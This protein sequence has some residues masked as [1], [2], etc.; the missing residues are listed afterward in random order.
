MTTRVLHRNAREMPPVAVGGKGAY[1]I[2]DHGCRYLDGS[3]VVCSLGY[4]HPAVIAAIRDQ[5]DALA[6]A[7]SGFFTTEALEG[8][9]A[10]LVARAPRSL[11]HAYAVSGGS[12]AVEAALKLA[13]QYFVERGQPGRRHVITRWRSV[14]T[15]LLGALA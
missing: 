9:A 12:E 10:D 6:Y 11:D 13:K 7:H 5:L 2:D 8:L 3:A 15:Q 4:G 14:H 1:L